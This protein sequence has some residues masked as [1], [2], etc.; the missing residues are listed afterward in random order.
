MTEPATPRQCEFLEILLNDLGYTTRAQRNAWLSA[1]TG[2]DIHYLDDLS[3]V[4]ASRLI[5]ELQRERD[6]A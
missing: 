1:E 2:K 6:G 5:D 3:K 4:E